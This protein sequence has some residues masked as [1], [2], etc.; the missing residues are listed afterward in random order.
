MTKISSLPKMT[1]VEIC[2]LVPVLMQILLS[3]LLSCFCY[4]NRITED[5]PIIMAKIKL[6][7][8]KM[9]DVEYIEYIKAKFRQ[10]M[11]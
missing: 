9:S 1:Y 6:Q 10:T 2:S 8:T 5:L 3:S 4:T 11:Q 7:P